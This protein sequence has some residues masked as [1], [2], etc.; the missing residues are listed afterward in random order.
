VRKRGLELFDQASAL[1]HLQGRISLLR[2]Y[3]GEDWPDCTDPALLARLEDWLVPWLDGITSLRA[4]RR[5]DPAGALRQWLGWERN[6]Q[7]DALLPEHY[8]TP[9]GSR[10][11]IDYPEDGDPVLRP[12]CRNS[13]AS[14]KPRTLPAD[15]FP[16][17]CT[18][19]RPPAAP[20]R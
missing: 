2:R 17:S 1:R 11:P 7:L 12:P 3:L 14:A 15:A 20:C 6:R 9:A 19:S 16:W 4:L 8:Q 10:R 13:T 5:V 18:C